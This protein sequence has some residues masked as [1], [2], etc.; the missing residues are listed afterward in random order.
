[1][2]FGFPCSP[3]GGPSRRRLRERQFLQTFEIRSGASRGPRASVAGQFGNHLGS[4][5]TCPARIHHRIRRA[6]MSG[7]H[8]GLRGSPAGRAGSP[9][10]PRARRVDAANADCRARIQLFVPFGSPFAA[11]G[12]RWDEHWPGRGLDN[13]RF[14]SAAT[15]WRPT[16]AALSIGTTFRCPSFGRVPLRAPGA[17]LSI[18]TRIRHAGQSPLS[19]NVAFFLWRAARSLRRRTRGLR[20]GW[21]G[22]HRGAGDDGRPARA[23]RPRAFSGSAPRR[24]CGNRPETH[25]R[26]RPLRGLLLAPAGASAQ[27]AWFDLSVS[28]SIGQVMG[29]EAP[30]LGPRFLRD[31]I[32]VFQD[33]AMAMANRAGAERIRDCLGDLQGLRTRWLEVRRVAGEVGLRRR[34]A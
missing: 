24:M 23:V 19:L 26:R 25:I 30:S 15:T 13:A 21:L 28:G 10:S 12:S 9:A 2:S 29:T 7:G 16:V 18:G 27:S 14:T 11:T 8:W 33:P 31:L 17:R 3:D 32:G 4:S 6:G 5:S 34:P 1:M 20:Q 22:A